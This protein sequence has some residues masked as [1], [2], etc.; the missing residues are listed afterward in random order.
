MGRTPTYTPGADR[1][2]VAATALGVPE[3]DAEA[4][5]LPA[6]A[7]DKAMARVNLPGDSRTRPTLPAQASDVARRAVAGEMKG[8]GNNNAGGNGG[9]RGGGNGGGNGGGRGGGGGRGRKPAG[10]SYFVRRGRP[11]GAGFGGVPSRRRRTSDGVGTFSG[12]LIPPAS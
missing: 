8:K 10:E 4:P 5:R 3:A 1:P 7:S 9:G 12:L 6:Q 2:V 11:M